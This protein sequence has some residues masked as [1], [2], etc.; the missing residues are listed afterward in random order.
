MYYSISM[1]N[2]FGAMKNTLHA[3]N[4]A[5]LQLRTQLYFRRRCVYTPLELPGTFRRY[6]ANCTDIN[7]GKK[8]PGT[9]CPAVSAK[10]PDSL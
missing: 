1:L 6:Q 10:N 8:E 2:S 9:S 7:K 5:L 4:T 3:A